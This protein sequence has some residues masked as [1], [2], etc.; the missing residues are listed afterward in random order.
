MEKFAPGSEVRVIRSIRND[1]SIH[2]LE[3]GE[4]LIPAGTIGI[5]RS[6]GYFLQ[7]QLIYQVFIPQLN[8]VIGVRDSEVIDA[9]L[10]WVPCLFRSQDKAKLKY[11]LQMFDKRLANKGDVIEVYRVHRNLKDGSLAYEIKFGPHYV[12]LDASVL[13]PLSSTAL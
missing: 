11:S 8:R 2:D 5:V 10:A 9:T 12:R 3:K 1:G 13:E 7:T 6:Y 4:L